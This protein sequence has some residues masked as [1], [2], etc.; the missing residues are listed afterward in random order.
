[1]RVDAAIALCAALLGGALIVAAPLPAAAAAAL[2]GCLVVGRLRTSVLCACLLGLLL[3]HGR[4]AGGLAAYEGERVAARDALGAP[5]RCAARARV[6]ASPVSRGGTLIYLVDLEQVQCEARTL[7]GRYRA[8]LYGGPG[9]LVRGDVADIVADLA[10]VRLFRNLGLGD[11]T[12]YAA[13]TGAVFSGSVL[14]LSLVASGGGVPAAIDRARA[15]ARQR[16]E[17]TFVP[18]VAPMARALVLGE[19]D[20]HPDD[21]QAFKL[22]GLAHILAVSGTHLVFAVVSLVALLRWIFAALPALAA[23]VDVARLACGVGVLLALGYA[24]FAG[25]SGSAWRAAWMLAAAF[26]ARACGRRPHGAR[27][28]ATSVFVGAAVDPLVA[29][30]LSFLLSLAA[31]GGLMTIGRPLARR[32]GEVQNVAVKYLAASVIATVSS[33]LPCAPLLALLSSELTLAGILANLIA[34]PIGELFALPLCLLHTLL[35]PLPLIERWV[36]VCASGALTVVK[37]V[38]HASAAA[39]LLAFQVPPPSGWQL[40][41]LGVALAAVLLGPVGS[42]GMRRRSRVLWS[43]AW[44]AGAGIA[45]CWLE[46]TERRVGAPT[47]V[48]RVTAIDVGQG[49][50]TLIDFPDGSTLLMDAGGF[51][52]SPVDPGARVIGPLLRERRRHRIDVVALSHPHPDHLLG[53]L[54]VVEQVAV[55]EFW[56]TGQ[57][58]VEGAGAAYRE[59]LQTLRAR[60]VP[61]RRPP[62]LC[63]APRRFGAAS[64]AVLD[65]CPAFQPGVNAND[66]SLVLHIRYGAHAVLLTGDAEQHQESRLIARFGGALAADLLKVGHH[67]SRTSTSR[68]FLAAVRP[69]LATISSGVRN[70]Y[71]HPHE[72]TLLHLGEA[73]VRALRLDR[74]GS[75]IWTSDGQ[76]F[77]AEAFSE[78]R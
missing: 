67:G 36:A 7:P 24:D 39:T 25:G 30:D 29:F 71:G 74:V 56:D 60:G 41:A 37:A 34:G 66:N 59:L 48:L 72:E 12:I 22:S 16:I 77:I 9:Q 61:I 49:D 65:P 64:V 73:K 10:P 40:A 33:M 14:S 21:D 28:V 32:F 70:R 45:L 53:L 27:S 52:G 1:M 47:N 20:L 69:T 3:G 6:V 4:A 57:G 26:A 68:E 5:S 31:T 17:A 78:E 38:A 13:R 58:E 76:R 43:F 8:R 51:M 23:R 44:C 11:P 15:H 35:E 50:A 19:N 18:T 2:L 75:V 63:A 55:G 54:A 46:A 62:E 42:P